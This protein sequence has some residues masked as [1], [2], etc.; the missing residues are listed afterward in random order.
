MAPPLP[1]SK[2]S[3]L[4]ILSA[5]ASTVQSLQ[6]QPAQVLHTADSRKMSSLPWHCRYSG[7]AF[8][9]QL[10]I[11][12]TVILGWGS[13]FAPDFSPHL[14]Q[15][16]SVSS[17][18]TCLKNLLQSVSLSFIRIINWV[19]GKLLCSSLATCPTPPWYSWSH[20]AASC[21][22]PLFKWDFPN[23]ILKLKCHSKWWLVGGIVTPGS[24][25]TIPHAEV[26]HKYHPGNDL[27]WQTWC[28]RRENEC[29]VWV[30]WCVL[31]PSHRRTRIS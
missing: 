15:K 8:P 2:K 29:W 20:W 31:W 12:E 18:T 10:K 22:P 30:I 17:F 16:V 27:I 28:V 23:F 13:G 1:F 21:A 26:R 4:A 24:L 25:L 9:G 7:A 5:V 11:Y 19:D 14:Q 3:E 6:D